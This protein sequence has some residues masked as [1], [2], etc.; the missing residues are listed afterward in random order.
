MK[1]AAPT[2]ALLIAISVI[3]GCGI[4]KRPLNG[5]S[6]R[7][8]VDVSPFEPGGKVDYELVIKAIN[9]RIAAVGLAGEAV[10]DPENPSRLIVN[11]SGFSKE[12]DIAG[13]L[14]KSY[15]LEMKKAARTEMSTFK[16]FD[17]RKEAEAALEDGEEAL[18]Y[19]ERESRQRFL[20][21]HKEAILKGEDIRDAQSIR[22]EDGNYSITLQ[23]KPA[24]AERFGQWT[25]QNINSY[26]AIVLDG[27]VISAPV[28]RGQI[29]DSAQIQGR[30]DKTSAD[31]IALGLRSGS[32]PA[33]IKI[34]DGPAAV[35]Q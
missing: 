25:G 23:L 13:Y 14:F 17:S 27:V 33:A 29:F 11:I 18:R 16:L 1:P 30:F 8:T 22:G 3:S 2:I 31:Q 21:V 6:A 26:L 5:E 20:L 19:D 15:R 10:R 9:F 7:W 35:S 12:M 34:I 32:L 28:I 4:L 24:A